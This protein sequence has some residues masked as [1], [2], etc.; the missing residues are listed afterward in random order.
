[1]GVQVT[2]GPEPAA[3]RSLRR[4]L[5]Q[6]LATRRRMAGFTQAQLGRKVGYSRSTVSTVE[7]GRQDV[8]RRFWEACDELLGTSG[9]MA[10]RFDRIQH[11]HAAERRSAAGATA[12]HLPAP[13][14]PESAGPED[15]AAYAQL[16]WPVT[17]GLA[18]LELETGSVL[19]A[20]ELNRPAGALAVHWWLGSGGTADQVR[21]LPALP[22][23]AEALAVT[24][25]DTS[26]FFLVQSGACPWH[27]R[28]RFPAPPAEAGL[29]RWHAEGSRI[30]VP[31]GPGAAWV[32][33]P[34]A[35]FRPVN[36]IPLLDLLAK[37]AAAVRRQPGALALHDG[38]LAVPA[39]SE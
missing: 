33:T 38:V 26:F 5:G 29:I 6:E 21:G 2:S 22:P 14:V 4:E 35:G 32:H 34:A 37:A 7:S 15:I 18:G 8:P 25:T 28:E 20:L 36:P 3:I 12:R 23:P 31:P 9:A 11:A 1:M 17:Q 16:G 30:P 39:W 19:D 24:V 10:G 27:A 13:R